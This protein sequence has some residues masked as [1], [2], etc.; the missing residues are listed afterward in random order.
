ML[1][2]TKGSQLSSFDG[3]CH[4]LALLSSTNSR[5]HA[6][7]RTVS[8]V[9]TLLN[10]ISDSRSATLPSLSK[11]RIRSA[12]GY[13]SNSSLLPAASALAAAAAAFVLG[14]EPPAPPAALRRA[15]SAATASSDG[16]AITERN[17]AAPP[18]Y[19]PR[20]A[21]HTRG[22]MSLKWWS[23]NWCSLR[24]AG[25]S[26][27]NSSRLSMGPGSFRSRESSSPA[28][29]AS[30]LPIRSSSSNPVYAHHSFHQPYGTRYQRSPGR[31]GA[32]GLNFL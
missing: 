20:N 9:S 27:I 26:S 4:N 16:T 23:G 6:R 30:L 24:C 17:T 10:T 5:R 2:S 11:R 12:G 15:L 31:P 8:S 22:A 3:R 28:L 13:N 32:A 19:H 1:R 25:R 21:S 18:P 7:A 29:T 14:A